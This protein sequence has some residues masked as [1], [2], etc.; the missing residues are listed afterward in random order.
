MLEQAFQA[1]VIDYYGLAERVVFAA[2]VDEG[3]AFARGLR[4]GAV[5]INDAALTVLI[6]EFEH[7]SFGLSGMGRSHCGSSAYVRFTRTQSVMANVA[8]KPLLVGALSDSPG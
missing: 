3:R 4:V 8:G 7:D 5:S 6:H 2:S 1:K